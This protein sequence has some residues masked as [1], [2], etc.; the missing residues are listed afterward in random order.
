[1]AIP[2]R[3]RWTHVHGTVAMTFDPYGRVLAAEA[4]VEKRKDR[5]S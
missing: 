2:F 5:R 4:E 3:K 1:M